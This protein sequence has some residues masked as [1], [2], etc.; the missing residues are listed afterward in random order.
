[1]N[2]NEH[3]RYTMKIALFMQFHFE[4]KIEFSKMIREYRYTYSEEGEINIII[5]K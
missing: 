3:T 4:W 1:M 5:M 2:M